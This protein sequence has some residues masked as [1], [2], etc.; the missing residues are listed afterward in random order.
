ME[1][2]EPKYAIYPGPVTSKTDGDEHHITA[3]N[4]A[5][6][7][8]VRLEDCIVIHASDFGTP[9]R[10]GLIERAKQLPALMP[11]YDGNY[12]LPAG[13]P[14]GGGGQPKGGA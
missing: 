1:M 4:L 9:W 2:A 10:R 3:P 7:Y 14:V 5:R 11:R 8:G 13:V 12:S 6:L